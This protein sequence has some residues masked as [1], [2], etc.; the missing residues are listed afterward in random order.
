M[1]GTTLGM[2]WL[3]PSRRVAWVVATLLVAALAAWMNGALFHGPSLGNQYRWRSEA[4][5]AG[6]ES[7]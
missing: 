5:H 1:L 2:L 4:F 3:A 6:R 7:P